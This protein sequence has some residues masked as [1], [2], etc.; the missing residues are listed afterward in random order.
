[1]MISRPVAVKALMSMVCVLFAY[2]AFVGLLPEARHNRDLAGIRKITT[3]AA[4][5]DLIVSP[6]R[7]NAESC[8]FYLGVPPRLARRCL[9]PAPLRAAPRLP[10]PV[11]S[12]DRS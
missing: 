9:R 6:S 4:P 11:P 8:R 12:A 5:D 10:Q 7:C 1:M 2:D 3:I